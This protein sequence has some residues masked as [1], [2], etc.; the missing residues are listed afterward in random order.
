MPLEPALADVGSRLEILGTR[1]AL[2]V[3]VIGSDISSS[4]SSG[5][6]TVIEAVPTVVTSLAGIEAVSCVLR[7]KVVVLAVPFHR[8]TELAAKLVPVTM[9]VNPAAPC[10]SDEGLRPVILG[11]AAPAFATLTATRAAAVRIRMRR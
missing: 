4:S 3:K 10:C 7:T 1:P 2:M 6:S 5:F 11:S 9:R 8:T